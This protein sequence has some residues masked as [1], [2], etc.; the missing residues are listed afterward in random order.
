MEGLVKVA[1]DYSND[2]GLKTYHDNYDEKEKAYY[3]AR[4]QRNPDIVEK[5]EHAINM[6]MGIGAGVG[7]GVGGLAGAAVGA[8]AGNSLAGKAVR[9]AG[10]GLLGGA[11]GAITGGVLGGAAS[12]P[13]VHHYRKGEDPEVMANYKQKQSELVNAEMARELAEEDMRK[14]YELRGNR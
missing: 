14:R 4:A 12:L 8:G 10:V 1:F 3:E 13:F 11:S 2:P 9:A 5:E 6:G 7:A